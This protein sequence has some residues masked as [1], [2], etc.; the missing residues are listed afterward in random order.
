[1]TDSCRDAQLPA[2][3]QQYPCP[4]LPTCNVRCTLHLYSSKHITIISAFAFPIHTL[5]QV[6]MA[7]GGEAESDAAV[8]GFLQNYL[9]LTEVN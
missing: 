6:E 7:A 9:H 5:L 3:Q 2:Q 8:S 1:M 4:V